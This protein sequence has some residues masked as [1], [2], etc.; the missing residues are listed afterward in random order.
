[1]RAVLNRPQFVRISRFGQF[2]LA[3]AVLAVAWPAP[4]A[5]SDD[6]P[7]LPFP[8]NKP[9]VITDFTITH[10]PGDLWTFEGTVDDENPSGVIVV[11]GGI[12]A[13]TEVPVTE[14]GTFSITI[15]L[16]HGT[17]GGVTAQAFDE[18]L[19]ASEVA[20]DVIE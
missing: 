12:I 2:L 10:Y 18:E 16:P 1:M 15:Q 6:R 13:G 5:I 14:E 8:L 17:K 7:N 4:V 11:F 20:E 9:P 19:Q 3:V